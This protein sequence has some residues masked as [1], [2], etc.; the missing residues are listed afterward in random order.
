MGK[1]VILRVEEWMD[2][3]HADGYLPN[4]Y[5]GFDSVVRT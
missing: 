5:G 2:D 3:N 4:Q 1:R